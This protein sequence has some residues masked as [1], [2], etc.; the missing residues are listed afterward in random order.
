MSEFG[1]QSFPEPRTVEPSPIP[2]IE[3]NS[4]IMDFRSARGPGNQAILNTY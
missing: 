1:F 4:W 2:K 3:I